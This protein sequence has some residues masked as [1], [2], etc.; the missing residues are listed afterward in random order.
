[1]PVPGRIQARGDAPAAMRT[2]R[3]F[4]RR[5]FEAVAVSDAEDPQTR[6]TFGFRATEEEREQLMNAMRKLAQ[7]ELAHLLPKAPSPAK[8]GAKAA[9]APQVAFTEER[10]ATL[11]LD[12]NNSAELV[13]T[14]RTA[15]AGGRSLYVTVVARTDVSGNPR[16]LYAV[17]TASDRLDVA[18]RLEFIDAVDADGDNRGELLFRRRR[19]AT[20]EFVL[21]RV[22]ADG[23]T[24]LFRGGNA[25]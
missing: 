23:L 22:G 18:P 7:S 13:Y 15:I 11:D 14:G 19:E 16:R 2:E 10:M 6:H 20:S 12:L 8:T 9:P 21:Y 5:A 24:E 4:A 1:M 25:E 17:L 3:G